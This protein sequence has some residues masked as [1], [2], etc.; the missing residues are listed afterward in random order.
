M[1]SGQEVQDRQTDERAQEFLQ[2]SLFC[3]RRSSI[4]DGTAVVVAILAPIIQSVFDE[5]WLKVLLQYI[6]AIAIWLLLR[7]RTRWM[8]LA[9]SYATNL[10]IAFTL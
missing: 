6:L 8:S 7:Q 2:A 3:D 4:W 5:S 9:A 1:T 10:N